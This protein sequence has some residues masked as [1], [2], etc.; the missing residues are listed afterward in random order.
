MFRSALI[1]LQLFML[2]ALSPV[3]GAA[4]TEPKIVVASSSHQY[5]INAYR[6]GALQFGTLMTLSGG[7]PVPASSQAEFT[8]DTSYVRECHNTAAP[9]KGT[10]TSCSKDVVTSG[11]TLKLTELSVNSVRV[12]MTRATLDSM[13]T[14]KEGDFA[15][16]TPHISKQLL[17]E[18]VVLHEGHAVDCQLGELT[19]RITRGKAGAG[20]APEPVGVRA[21]EYTHAASPATSPTA[22]DDA[23]A[24][25]R[26]VA[27]TGDYML[28]QTVDP[29]SA[30][31]S[32]YDVVITKGT[33]TVYQ[34]R[35]WAIDGL[36]APTSSQNDM[37]GT[38][39]VLTKHGDDVDIDARGWSL[40]H[41][42][43]AARVDHRLAFGSVH[44][45]DKGEV[46]FTNDNLT[47]LVRRLDSATRTA[48][49]RTASV[50]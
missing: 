4:T 26:Q 48:G 15:I 41:D 34:A 47:V 32:L 17:S 16:Q 3:A 43:Q 29:S 9:E 25:I 45:P 6:D 28:D 23:P 19:I 20:Q 12:E 30:G 39:V 14:V 36:S 40:P 2:S 1:A 10:E 38:Y 35:I 11:F 33:Q 49:S 5:A 8:K 13:P 31:R 27:I 18:D 21:G 7:G 50:P 46:S 22:H 42:G 24:S 44:L 37:I